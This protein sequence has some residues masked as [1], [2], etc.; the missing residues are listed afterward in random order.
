[1]GEWNLAKRSLETF[2]DDSFVYLKETTLTLFRNCNRIRLF[3]G[4]VSLRCL[5]SDLVQALAVLKDFG[6]ILNMDLFCLDRSICIE[7]SNAWNNV[8]GD[9]LFSNDDGSLA[10][11]QVA[12][13]REMTVAQEEQEVGLD[14]GWYHP[15]AQVEQRL[16]V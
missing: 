9:D 11:L 13:L 14:A 16:P 4:T 8:G 1:M 6:H 5:R 12:Q 3:Y 2:L 15:L 7:G 10:S